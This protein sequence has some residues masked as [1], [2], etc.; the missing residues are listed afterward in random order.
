MILQYIL[1]LIKYFLIKLRII[2]KPDFSLKIVKQHPNPDELS[3]DHIFMIKNGNL[4]KYLCFNCPG[5]CKGKVMLPLIC[6]S[7]WKI[8]TDW[9]NRPSIKPSIRL[10]NKCHCHFWIKNGKV[11]WCMDGDFY[12]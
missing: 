3:N 2:K 4:K 6:P 12:S 5:K 10:L 11:I 9:L 7:K 1:S 8:Q